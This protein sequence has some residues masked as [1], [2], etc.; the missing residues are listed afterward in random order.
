MSADK[1][2]KIKELL[3]NNPQ[4]MS[5]TDLVDELQVNK[6]SIGRY[7]DTLLASGQVEMR[8]FG[9]AKVYTLSNRLP[10]AAML[11]ISSDFILVLDNNLGIVNA[12]DPLVLALNVAEKDLLGKNLLYSPLVPFF[13]R[14]FDPL[15]NH[16]VTGLNGTGWEGE[17]RA[18][19]MGNEDTFHCRIL[20]TVFETGQHGVSV[21]LS[22]IGYQ[23]LREEQLRFQADLLK[24][25][26]EA[27]VATDREGT[28]IYWNDAAA[29][30]FQYPPEEA[31][32][33]N[34]FSHVLVD[35]RAQ[36][37]ILS[38]I[39][40][41]GKR[42]SGEHIAVRKNRARFPISLAMA[43]RLDE[44][45]AIV[46]FI[47]T[48]SDISAEKKA[49]K[50]LRESELRYHTLFDNALDGTV[51]LDTHATIL[52]IN[53]AAARMF[54][55]SDTGN[56]VGKDA[57][58]FI[59]TESRKAAGHY[60]AGIKEGRYLAENAQYPPLEFECQT[61]SGKKFWIEAIG[62]RI[63]YEDTPL[64]LF[65]M[66]DITSRRQEEKA[67]REGEEKYRM[68]FE[69]A[70]DMISLYELDGNDMPGP[71]LEINDV[72]CHMLGYSREELLTLA[73]QDVYAPECIPRMQKTI[74]LYHSQHHVTFER[75][76]VA[77]DGRR[78][79]VEIS[80][81]HFNRNGKDVVLS[82]S[83]DITVTKNL[84]AE[85]ESTR[86]LLDNF[87]AFI[88]SALWSID[89]DTGA[90]QFASPNME[91]VTGKPDLF[92]KTNSF[93]WITVIHPDDR[94]K[95]ETQYRDLKKTGKFGIEYRMLMPDGGFRH[96]RDTVQFVKDEKTKS[97][98]IC[99]MTSLVGNAGQ[100]P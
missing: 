40:R 91:E 13:D 26:T 57:L 71:F 43:P 33:N 3:K 25:I 61:L 27:V 42:W 96:L 6:N 88:P 92:F 66:R 60:I 8:R 85:L 5:V 99:G 49:D 83:R 36:E 17:V 63:I 2:Q 76:Y 47:G 53:T 16:I 97:P 34:F 73:P 89:P 86:K 58:D 79:P 44:A 72:G 77:K 70:S 62:T 56:A 93:P 74:A 29:N 21:T 100:T 22:D 32:G 55:I 30:L 35:A 23:K 14:N 54:E 9:M 65:S 41:E 7:L 1:I 15:L 4:G 19:S 90:C 39:L 68:L 37:T 94:K 95:Y 67:I 75:V 46:G 87:S 52:M 10:L 45:G 59:T 78:I 12:N 81:H 18:G 80:A 64:F 82:I 28:I 20:P 38:Y 31:A 50:R 24:D 48:A 84:R 11:S 98:R 69:N 51:L